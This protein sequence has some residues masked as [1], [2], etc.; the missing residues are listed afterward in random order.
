MDYVT[1][2]IYDLKLHWL[3][4][5]YGWY[6]DRFGFYNLGLYYGFIDD[7]VTI[8]ILLDGMKLIN[9]FNPNRIFLQQQHSPDGRQP[10]VQLQ[11][12]TFLRLCWTIYTEKISYISLT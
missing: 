9:I 6:V 1:M 11:P 8:Y 7:Y 10:R 12:C 4:F 2:P 3:V 5:K